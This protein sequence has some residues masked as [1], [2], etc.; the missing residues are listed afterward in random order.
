M[1][2]I[3]ISAHNRVDDAC[4]IPSF[5]ITFSRALLNHL[6]KGC[7]II[8]EDQSKTVVEY[9]SLFLACCYQFACITHCGGLHFLRFLFFGWGTWRSLS[10][11]S[12][13]TLA[14][15]SSSWVLAFLTSSLHSLAASLYFPR[16]LIQ[17]GVKSV[18]LCWCSLQ[19]FQIYFWRD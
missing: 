18:Q 9:L 13:H 10:C 1:V 5:W 17:T 8:R 3:P 11:S 14:K 15:F 7:V 16:Y 12:R 6:F 2:K 4:P 19:L